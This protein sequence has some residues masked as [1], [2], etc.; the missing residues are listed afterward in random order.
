[1]IHSYILLSK[2]LFC[3][4]R[5]PNFRIQLFGKNKVKEN[6]KI[7]LRQDIKNLCP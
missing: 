6:P 4:K 1:M 5:L 3:L 2:T 7:R